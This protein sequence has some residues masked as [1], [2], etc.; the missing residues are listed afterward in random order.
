MKNASKAV[1]AV[2]AGTTAGL[3]VTRLR[4]SRA[5]ISAA[6]PSAGPRNRWRSVTVKK[7]VAEVTP[8]GKLPEP[9]AA[10]GELVEVRVTPAPGGK[11][12]EIAAR[13][14]APKPSG[15]AALLRRLAGSDPRQAVRS[16]LRESKALIETGGALR[17]DPRPAGRR[18]PTPAGKLL[19]IVTGRARAEGML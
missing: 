8:D 2:A 16:A 6:G 9:L 17:V 11:G 15:P 1:A 4:R 18:T 13:L 14:R 10:L 3:A 19:D 12:T 5:R 7:P